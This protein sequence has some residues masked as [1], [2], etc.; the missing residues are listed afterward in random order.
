MPC[1]PHSAVLQVHFRNQ[2]TFMLHLLS[3]LK[4]AQYPADYVS[5]GDADGCWCVGL[6]ISC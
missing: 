6:E 3:P 4:A 1:L 5:A 2:L